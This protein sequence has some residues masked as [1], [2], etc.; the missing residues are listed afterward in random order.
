MVVDSALILLDLIGEA[1]QPAIWVIGEFLGFIIGL[2]LS[3]LAA[4]E[5]Y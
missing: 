3:H 4:F 2:N 5:Q 1:P